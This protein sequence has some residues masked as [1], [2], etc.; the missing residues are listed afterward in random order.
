MNW[1]TIGNN[2]SLIYMLIS[3]ISGIVITFYGM[4]FYNKTKEL[5]G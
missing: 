3:L 5:N 4:K 2:S 1:Q